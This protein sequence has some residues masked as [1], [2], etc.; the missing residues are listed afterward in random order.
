MSTHAPALS[1]L[2]SATLFASTASGGIINGDFSPDF[3]GWD[4]LTSDGVPPPASVDPDTATGFYGLPGGG[5]AELKLDQGSSVFIV[6][7]FQ[8]FAYP[9]IGQAIAVQFDWDWA[10]SSGVDGDSFQILL[11]DGLGKTY[12][13]VDVM[14]GTPPDLAA[15]AA[16]ALRTDSF[17]I[18]AGYFSDPSLRFS[19][20]L[21]DID[22][23]ISDTLRIGNISISIGSV[24]APATWLLLSMGGLALTGLRRR[25]R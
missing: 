3:T 22:F 11:E 1:L 19:A 16:A 8:D 18:P 13:F 20:Q 4:G 25:R 9:D 5:L 7:L 2:F 24:P 14:F 10:P 12:N 21:T 23:D 6:E 17:L 15:A